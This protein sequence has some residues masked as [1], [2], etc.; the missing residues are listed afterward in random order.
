M[1]SWKQKQTLLTSLSWSQQ[2]R[3]REKTWYPVRDGKAW[4]NQVFFLA[5]PSL[6]P[7]LM[8]MTLNYRSLLHVNQV[9]GS[10]LILKG[11]PRGAR[12]WVELLRCMF[13]W[14]I[15]SFIPR[16][17]LMWKNLLIVWT[18][19]SLFAGTLSLPCQRMIVISVYMS[20][21]QRFSFILKY[22]AGWSMPLKLQGFYLARTI[23]CFVNINRIEQLLFLR[24]W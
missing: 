17:E 13:L 4:K 9:S 23:K 3:K 11:P 12:L 1:V 21:K 6:D 7:I 18:L 15:E 19:L 2:R 16:W 5:F 20:H 10:Y 8:H 24:W 14:L 22:L